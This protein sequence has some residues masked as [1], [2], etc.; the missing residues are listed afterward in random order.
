MH[1][2]NVGRRDFMRLT[3]GAFAIASPGLL[4]AQSRL[5]V[6]AVNYPLAY[7]AERSGGELAE[8]LFP[9]PSG[10]DPSFWRPGIAD[11]S[12]FQGADVILLNGGGFADW[13]ART[14][15]PRSRLVMTSSA[16]EDQFIATETVTHSHGDGGEHSHTGT[17]NYFW[18]DFDLATQQAQAIADAMIRRAPEAE[19]T[20]TSNLQAL[21][22]DLANLGD[23]ARALGDA[24]TETPIIAS[25]PRYQYLARAYNLSIASVDWDAAD[26]PSEAQFQSLEGLVAEQNAKVFVW[27]AEPN[28]NALAQIEALGMTNAVVPPLANAPDAGDFVSVMETSL[29]ALRSA[30]GE[31]QNL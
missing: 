25:H 1:R 30:I 7:F 17:A 23:A 10:T 9:V 31:A 14:T 20:L 27:E 29:N 15:L 3:A 11:I 22:T 8:V 28:E 18:L 26:E 16:F 19:D 13:T 12:A 4:T 5:T 2:L 21:Q 24:A 6:A